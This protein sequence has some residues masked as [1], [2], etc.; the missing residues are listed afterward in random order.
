MRPSPALIIAAIALFIGLGG[1][2]VA[3]TAITSGALDG[4]GNLKKN[5]VA[6]KNLKKNAVVS[7]KIKKGKVTGS[8]LADGA[9]GGEKVG[10]IAT[11]TATGTAA[12]GGTTI[13]ATCTDGKAIGG[14]F[15]A[16][17]ASGPGAV[18]VNTSK[19]TD[20]GWTATAYTAGT[21]PVAAFTAYVYCLDN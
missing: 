8:K 12:P 4:K 20:S 5:A 21:P 3:A 9:V 1:G 17:P 10:S 18:F 19:K 2:A 13:T 6:K 7:S 15:E 14:G 16:P 11:V